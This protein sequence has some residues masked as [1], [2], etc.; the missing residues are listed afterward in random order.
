M[1]AE[2]AR[3][4]HEE[5]LVDRSLRGTELQGIVDVQVETGLRRAAVESAFSGFE[6]VNWDTYNQDQT[7][8]F[9]AR[10]LTIN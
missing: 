9:V 8:G 3:R 6:F 2:I 10:R 1:L 5:R 4:L 7:F